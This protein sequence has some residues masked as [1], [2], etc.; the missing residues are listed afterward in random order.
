[1]VGRAMEVPPG[2]IERIAGGGEAA[3]KGILAD[4]RSMR[5]NGV[6]RTSVFRGDVPSQGV[7]V[8]RDGDGVLAEHRSA[9]SIEGPGAVP[10]VL[11]DAASDKAQLEVRTYDYGHSKISLDHLQGSHPDAAGEGIGDLGRGPAGAG[12]EGGAARGGH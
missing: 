1:M 6:L 7:V 3:L 10:E 11:R 5:F 8:F 2:R 4:V 9:E 12:G